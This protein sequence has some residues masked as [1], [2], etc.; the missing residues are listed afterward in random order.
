MG[1][2]AEILADV[3]GVGAHVK[4]FRAVYCEFDLRQSDAINRVVGDIHRT[5]FALH[6]NAFTG[7]FIEGH[8]VFLNG[9]NHW[10]DLFEVAGIFIE[11]GIDLF[12]SEGGD[13]LFL[14]DVTFL[15]L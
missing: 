14:Q 11:R 9:R 12:G 7:E 4:T 1:A 8:A 2:T 6:L 13:F 15:V 5:R 3:M 10:R